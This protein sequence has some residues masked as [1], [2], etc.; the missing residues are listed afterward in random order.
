MEFRFSNKS[1]ITIKKYTDIQE[2]SKELVPALTAGSVALSGGSTYS[3]LCEEW[4]KMDLD[5]TG[6]WYC[7]VDERVVPIDSAESNWKLP[8]KMFLAADVPEQTFNH[9]TT[10]AYLKTLLRNRFDKEPYSFDTM[11]LGVGEDGHTAS[12]FPDSKA[13]TNR[14]AVALSTIS[15]K[16]IKERVTLGPKV[17]SNAKNII[18]VMGGESKRC[19][20]TWL[21]QEDMTKPFVS[22]LSSAAHSTLYLDPVLYEYMSDLK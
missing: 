11:F 6:S 8:K 13:F 12:L 4:I 15:P 14:A 17:I 1:T 22:I 5:L 18:T 2:L 7:A 10:E 3:A 16:G 21:L 20:I 19:C 9:Y